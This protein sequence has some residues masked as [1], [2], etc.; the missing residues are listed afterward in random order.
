[1]DPVPFRQSKRPKHIRPIEPEFLEVGEE[2]VS[3]IHPADARGEVS[4]SN[5]HPRGWPSSQPAMRMAAA[6]V[7]AAPPCTL[8]RRPWLLPTT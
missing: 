2:D 8:E 7:C 1:V 3:Q 4:Q 6:R 5:G